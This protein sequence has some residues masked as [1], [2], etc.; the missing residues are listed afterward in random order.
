MKSSGDENVTKDKENNRNAAN[1]TGT[2]KKFLGGNLSLSGKIFDVGSKEAIH[3]FADTTKA[4]ADYVGQ[5]YMHS[6]DIRYMLENLQEFN[7]TRPE[8]SAAKANQ[9]EVESWKKLLDLYWKCRGVYTDNKMKL[10]SLKWGQSTK[11]IDNKFSVLNDQ[12][13]E[14]GTR[15]DVVAKEEHIPE[16]ERQIRVIKERARAVVQTLP[17]NHMPKKMIIGLI[18]YT[19]YW[20]NNIAKSGQDNLPRDLILGQKLNYKVICRIPF[21][22]YAQVHDDPKTTNTMEAR[23][24]GAINMGPTGNVHRTHIFLSLKTGEVIVRRNWTEMPIP[25]EAI[26]RIQELSRKEK[27]DFDNDESEDYI[28]GTKYENEK[29]SHVRD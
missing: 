15:V 11:M 27:I 26:V 19:T 25:S 6:G 1:T 24:I 13:E 28:H 29:E 16:V 8:D 18:Q 5:E 20:L 21:G 4:I 10:Y 22:T 23:T 9:Y 14:E 3:Q 12:I 7:F 2:N 17:Y